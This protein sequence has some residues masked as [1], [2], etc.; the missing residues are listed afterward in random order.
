[1]EF[2]YV[3]IRE[4]LKRYALDSSMFESN[5]STVEKTGYIKRSQHF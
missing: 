4:I 5:G 1:M 3:E 2:Y